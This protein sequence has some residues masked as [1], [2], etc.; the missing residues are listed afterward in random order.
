MSGFEDQLYLEFLGIVNNI[1]IS[2]K[3]P[4]GVKALFLQDA[5]E[6]QLDSPGSSP[7]TSCTLVQVRTSNSFQMTQKEH[8]MNWQSK[9]RSCILDRSM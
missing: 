2:S 8:D 9:L 5:K 1:P 4:K 6:M 3:E 7:G